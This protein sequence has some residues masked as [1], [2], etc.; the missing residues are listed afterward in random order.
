M[1]NL[2]Q[3]IGVLVHAHLISELIRETTETTRAYLSIMF[4]QLPAS[5]AIDHDNEKLCLLVRTIIMQNPLRVPYHLHLYARTSKVR[6]Q[7]ECQAVI[8]SDQFPES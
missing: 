5:I 7:T 1:V 4:H 3:E 6:N 8:K 2:E